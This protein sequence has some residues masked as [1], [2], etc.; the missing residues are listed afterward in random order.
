MT[1]AGVTRQGFWHR[2]GRPFRATGRGIRYVWEGLELL[3][4]VV[5]VGRGLVWLVRGVGRAVSS[6]VDW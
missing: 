6:I 5:N 4:L 3:S 1:T 2:V